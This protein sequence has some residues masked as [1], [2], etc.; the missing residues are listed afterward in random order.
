MLNK[1]SWPSA[2]GHLDRSAYGCHSGNQHS[3]TKT[4]QDQELQVHS[5]R[6]G[7]SWGTCWNIP[8]NG[9]T[10]Q[11]PRPAR[12]LSPGA[13]WIL[14]PDSNW[15]LEICSPPFP[16]TEEGRRDRSSS[17]WWPNTI[18]VETAKTLLT[19]SHH[20]VRHFEVFCCD[21]PM[22]DMTKTL[23]R[24]KGFWARTFSNDL[25]NANTWK[26]IWASN[27]FKPLIMQFVRNPQRANQ[28]RQF[29]NDR[30][31]E[32][33]EAHGI[34]GNGLEL[35]Q[36]P[37]FRQRSVAV[38]RQMIPNTFSM[39]IARVFPSST[40][41]ISLGLTFDAPWR[42]AGYLPRGD[43]GGK[44]ISPEERELPSQLC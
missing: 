27:S 6:Q 25:K 1:T 3:T 34:V 13:I 5:V 36:K 20:L 37:R 9:V 24:E 44:P 4:I 39:A 30:W 41:W 23:F 17:W 16:M 22:T 14:Q 10:D 42:R 2:Y 38:G 18:T 28:R 33:V 31:S 32:H 7:F 35:L 26:W 40:I 19:E 29:Q 11:K 43:T 21:G 12:C 8:T 15:I